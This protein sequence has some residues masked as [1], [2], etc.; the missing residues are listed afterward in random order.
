MDEGFADLDK[1]L[2]R[3]LNKQE[4]MDKDLTN[5]RLK[6]TAQTPE[7]TRFKAFINTVV[8]AVIAI[9][10]SIMIYYLT[11]FYN[12]KKRDAMQVREPKIEI[13]KEASPPSNNKN[14]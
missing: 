14:Q 9:F 7:V 5:L 1:K 4:S 11:D 6:V 2:D 13:E 10:V 3:I 8:G 12:S